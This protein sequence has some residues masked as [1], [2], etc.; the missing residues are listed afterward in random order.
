MFQ[1]LINFK[2][3][4]PIDIE[5]IDFVRTLLILKANSIQILVPVLPV[6]D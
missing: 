4:S 3:M 5:K 2:R 1:S 6:Q